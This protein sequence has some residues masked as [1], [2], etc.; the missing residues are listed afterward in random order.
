MKKPLFIGCGTALVTPFS[1]GEVDF[2]ALGQLIDRQLTGG[3]DALIVCGTTGE[4]A[5]LT[6]EEK[7]RI[8][9]LALEKAAGRIPVIAGAGCNCTKLTILQSLR[10]QSLGADGLLIV[11]P[12][13]NKT[14]QPGLIAHYT[15]VADAVSL[16]IILYNVPARTGVNM[17]PETAARLCA[18]PNI[19]GLKEAGISLPAAAEFLRLTDG[20]AALYSGNDD[21]VLPMLS[22]GAQ[23]VIS[24]VSN[25]VPQLV[26]EMTARWLEGDVQA[27]RRIQL[28]LLPLCR[29]LFSEVSPIPVKGAL[30]MLGL[31]S[32]EM[33][34][35]LVPLTAP[36]KAAL[37]SALSSLGLMK[38]RA[39]TDAE[40]G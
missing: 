40:G 24:V 30:E 29:A 20:S 27:A 39:E 4:P 35:P 7:D 6:Q 12:Y 17:L 34:L 23:G 8:L 32:G 38:E 2:P 10:A 22:L 21:Q 26:H 31:C 15:A 19:I 28:Q 13:Y 37:A 14:T 18:H 33:R 25:I 5:S 16:P 1:N 36:A 9:S 11:T 3:A